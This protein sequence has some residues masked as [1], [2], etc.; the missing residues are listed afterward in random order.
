M[1]TTTVMPKDLTRTAS[2]GQPS[3]PLG[4]DWFSEDLFSS[5]MPGAAS[6]RQLLR[7]IDRTF[8]RFFGATAGLGDVIVAP[9][10]D[11]SETEKEW[12]I[13][14]EMPG[15]ALKDIQVEVR[16]GLL[17]LSGRSEQSREEKP[18]S[19]E[20]DGR[21]YWRKERRT[22]WLE[23]TLSLPT[24]VDEE[25]ITCDYQNGILTCHVPKTPGASKGRTIPIGGS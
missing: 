23:R 16:E 19:K 17:R 12:I 9:R 10:L 6:T 21:Q 8:D 2:E 20:T 5:L 22:Q 25:K 24:G 7:Q 11:I 13:E 1:S 3:S 14:A 15:L 18:E 4:S